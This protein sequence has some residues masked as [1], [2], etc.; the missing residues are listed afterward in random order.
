MTLRLYYHPLASFCWK[1]L[2]A[3][4]EHGVTFEPVIVD[5]M[6]AEQRE[7]FAKI[8]PLAKMPGLVD[9]TRAK[10]VFES[11]AVIDYIDTFYA[12]GA[13]LIPINP[14][15]AWR[16]RMWNSFFDSYLHLPMQKIVIDTFRPADSKDAFG[17][18]EAH[19]TIRTAYA[20]LD[21]ELA[22]AEGWLAGGNF[23][24]AEC[25]AVPALFYADCVEPLGDAHAN[26]AAYMDR[27][28][29][30]PSVRRTLDEAAPHFQNFP[31]PRKPQI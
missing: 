23:T 21:V 22:V 18:A 11:E 27:L 30:H 4:Y 10:T 2:I 5:M 8:S 31:F 24:L 7:A 25:A 19:A 17:V 9:S 14:D 6:D 15:H 29:A 26:V 1:A 16:A 3:L 13:E 28:R 20:A 12:G